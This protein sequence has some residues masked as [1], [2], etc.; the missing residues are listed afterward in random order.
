MTARR[1]DVRGSGPE[2]KWRIRAPMALIA[3][4]QTTLSEKKG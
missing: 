2:P 4:F 3:R 1:A